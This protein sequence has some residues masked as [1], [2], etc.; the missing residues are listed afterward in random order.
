MS[1]L[2]RKYLTALGIDSDK[3]DEIIE[4][5]METVNSLKA[6]IDEAKSGSEDVS[7][8]KKENETLKA[9]VKEL[10]DSSEDGESYKV[11]Y[12]ALK[13]E[14]ENYKKGI[15]AEKTKTNKVKAYKQLLADVGISEKRRDAVCK[16]ADFSKIELNEDGSIKDADNLKKSLSEEWED[17]IEKKGTQGAESHNPPKNE[18]NGGSA[19]TKEEILKIKDS[20]ER[21]QAIAENIELFR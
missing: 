17:F 14:H 9:K 13:N 18:G 2:T 15:E 8:L 5:H 19:K 11:K 20:S 4:A 1:R 12:E 16:V 6:E 7:K 21:Q 3:Q 10:E